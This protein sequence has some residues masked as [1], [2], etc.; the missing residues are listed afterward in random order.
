MI[1][2]AVFLAL[3]LVQSNV[4]CD[5]AKRPDGK[6]YI[7]ASPENKNAV[8]A[9]VCD[10]STKG[11][12]QINFTIITG[13]QGISGR[14]SVKNG[15]KEV[16]IP[17]IGLKVGLNG[18]ASPAIPEALASITKLLE[19]AK[20]PLT[21]TAIDPPEGNPVSIDGSA[22]ANAFKTATASCKE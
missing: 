6:L 19:D 2:P 17:M 4:A 11:I 21:L 1:A 20:G 5:W 18:F 9:F 10:N 16:Q 12:K 13:K 8:V 3:T 22:I 14:M 15:S 7:C